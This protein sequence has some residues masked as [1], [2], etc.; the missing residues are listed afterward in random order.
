MRIFIIGLFVMLVGG[1]SIIAQSAFVQQGSKLVGSDFEGSSKQGGSVAIS[2]DGT[3][4]VVGGWADNSGKGAVWVHIRSTDNIWEQQGSK[5]IG[6]GAI[7]EAKQGDV[8]ISADGNTIIIGGGKDDS[9]KG[10]VWIFVRE[11]GVWSQQGNKLIGTGAIG[12]G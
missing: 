12:T 11:S 7:G 2:A 9:N 4:A 3:T 6:T 8:A 5:L 1:N 10:A